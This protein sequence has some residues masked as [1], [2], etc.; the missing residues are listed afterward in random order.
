[1]FSFP[2]RIQTEKEIQYGYGIVIGCEFIDK[3]K[4]RLLIHF[5]VMM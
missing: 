2:L 1:M 3:T 5:S 4:C